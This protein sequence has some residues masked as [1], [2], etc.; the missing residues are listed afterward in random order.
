M[1]TLLLV[2]LLPGLAACST[3]E[4][5][6]DLSDLSRFIFREW[7]ADNP[8]VLEQAMVNLEASLSEVDLEGERID[9]SWVLD[10][11]EEEDVDGVLHPADRDPAVCLSVTL[12][13]LSPWPVED[14]AR[15]QVEADQ[16]LAE[17]T[18][19]VYTRNFTEPDDPAC[20][21]SGDCL[22]VRT[23][24]D[25]RREN[26]LMSI[27]FVL[28][29]DFRWVELDGGERRALVARSW[30]DQSWTGDS[31][32][33]HLWQSFAIDVWLG[34]EDGSTWRYQALWSESEVVDGVTEETIRATVRIAI[35]DIFAAGDS[36]IEQ[37]YHDGS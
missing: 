18:S 37:L 34:Q 31:G 24:N 10:S 15:L 32:A 21:P 22:L 30:M 19:P 8:V 35:D 28:L 2:L 13:G 17:P 3:P 36:A 9:R 33:T 20:F 14:H 11:I 23:S 6:S 29:K 16:A 27:D 25:V 12:S 5:P 4:A 26:L 1:R 7:E